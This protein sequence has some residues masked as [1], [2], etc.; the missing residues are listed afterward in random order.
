MQLFPQSMDVAN[1][2]LE[3]D[4]LSSSFNCMWIFHWQHW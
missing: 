1:D 3:L 4:M 2:S